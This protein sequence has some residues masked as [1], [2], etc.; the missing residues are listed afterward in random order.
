MIAILHPGQW[1]V[2]L[3]ALAA[4]MRPMLAEDD[5]YKPL[6]KDKTI[7]YKVVTKYQ[8]EKSTTG[9]RLDVIATSVKM[10]NMGDKARTI[11]VCVAGE[12]EATKPSMGPKKLT[13][14][15]KDNKLDCSESEREKKL[16]DRRLGNMGCQKVALAKKGD[17]GDEKEL[18]FY[19]GGTS[20][21]S[22]SVVKVARPHK[23]LS[24]GKN[25]LGWLSKTMVG[26]I[27]L[28]DDSIGL[29]HCSECYAM[30]R[31]FVFPPAN[32]EKYVV[33]EEVLTFAA[34]DAKP[35]GH[36][37]ARMNLHSPGTLTADQPVVAYFDIE[38][39]NVPLSPP[40]ERWNWFVDAA[41]PQEFELFTVE[42]WKTPTAT[43]HVDFPSVIR[44]D[45][46]AGFVVTVRQP[47]PDGVP[48]P[49]DPVLFEDWIALRPPP[50]QLHVTAYPSN[51]V[52][53]G[54]QIM[55]EASV[56]SGFIGAPGRAVEFRVLT[57]DVSLPVDDEAPDD[58]VLTY[59]T[60]FDG[61]LSVE[62]TGGSPG[63][64]L[65]QAKEIGTGMTAYV[66]LE[67]VP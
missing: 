62:A 46:V 23:P 17:A 67:V 56:Q 29:V 20:S 64:A 2:V 52:A 21:D 37:A 10:K 63:V 43:L 3:A 13:I 11:V 61:R 66:V 44:R 58:R 5:G 35:L 49:D 18:T 32:A 26:F 59:F 40:E 38:P 27:L 33:D 19:S 15:F 55:L 8:P 14:E 24:D 45:L 6:A 57:G 65:V 9:K 39:V 7:L 47:R 50:D 34:L 1:A 31:M 12:S 48:R 53:T 30:E 41:G 54:G 4:S 60:H 36:V 25:P 28:V 22:N 42:P 51:R 16:L